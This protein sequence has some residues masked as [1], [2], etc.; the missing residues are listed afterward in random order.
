MKHATNL[1][2]GDNMV[3]INVCDNCGAILSKLT[4]VYNRSYNHN[5]YDSICDACLEEPV[6]NCKIFYC[7]GCGEYYSVDE[8]TSNDD[9]EQFCEEC[10]RDLYTTCS[11]CN[12]ILLID[13]STSVGCDTYCRH[14]IDNYFY[15]CD[16]CVDYVHQ[17]DVHNGGDCNVYCSDCYDENRNNNFKDYASGIIDIR[18]LSKKDS[19]NVFGVEIEAIA[20]NEFDNEVDALKHFQI[21]ED[22]SLSES[23]VEFVSVPLP[24]PSGFKIISDFYNNFAKGELKINKSCGLHIHLFYP[25]ELITCTNL[26]KIILGYQNLEPLFYKMVSRSRRDNNYCRSLYGLDRKIVESKYT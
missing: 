19:F 23:G 17:D 26:K 11:N 13:D 21:V 5:K 15:V 14:C 6:A 20:N 3:N 8:V 1:S 12:I 25:Y 10:W 7:N 4:R 9:G 24:N 2:G 18:G 16:S 22:G